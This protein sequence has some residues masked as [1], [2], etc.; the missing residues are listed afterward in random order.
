MKALRV[1]SFI[2]MILGVFVYL[3]GYLSRIQH[4]PDILKGKISGQIILFLGV[5]LYLSYIFSSQKDK[6]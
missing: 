5:V 1:T 4:W 3:F 6:K 2:L